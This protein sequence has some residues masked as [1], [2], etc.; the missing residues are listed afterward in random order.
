M[1]KLQKIAINSLGIFFECLLICIITFAFLIRTST[2]Q[3]FLAGKIV[4]Y[5][6]NELNTR[7]EIEGVEIIF[8][9]KISLS[10]ILIL[11]Q[12]NDTII[13]SKSITLTLDEIDFFNNSFKIKK[14]IC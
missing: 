10:G 2:F 6:S 9:D 4:A 11:D 8:F 13:A 1:V 3:T 5:L 7:I 12:H 14:K